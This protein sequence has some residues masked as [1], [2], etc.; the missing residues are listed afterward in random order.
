MEES[1]EELAGGRRVLGGGGAANP[2]LVS[3][4]ACL[5]PIQWLVCG[6]AALG[7]AFD[8]YETLVTALIA[9]PALATLG[10]FKLGSPGLQPL[11]GTDVLSAIGF[12]WLLWTSGRLPDRRFRPSAWPGVEP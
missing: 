11:G 7:F 10:N 6:V 2:G 3:D 4:F 9:R 5:T 8:L 12:G 1:L